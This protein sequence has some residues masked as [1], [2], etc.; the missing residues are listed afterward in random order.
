MGDDPLARPWS[1]SRDRP[2]P[3]RGQNLQAMLGR[4]WP[5]PARAPQAGQTPGAVLAGRRLDDIWARR[6]GGLRHLHS[7]LRRSRAWWAI[8]LI[9]L[10]TA[11]A[12]LLTWATASLAEGG[13]RASQAATAISAGPLVAPAPR[14]AGGLPLRLYTNQDRADQ[15]IITQL[16]QKFS[17]V[18]S[19]LLAVAARHGGP[20]ASA[21]VIRPSG[22]YGE[23]GHLDPLTSR[24]S[25]VMY[26]GLQSPA[27]LG[28][29]AS[30]IGTLMMGI[31]GKYS[32]I[33]PWP[34]AAGHRGGQGSC[35]VAWLGNTDVSVCGWAS[36]RTVGIVASPARE[37]SVGELATLLIKMRYGLQRR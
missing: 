20:A 22:L 7:A 4:A 25:W 11:A 27:S 6:P 14:S 31:L 36:G 1:V 37:T 28:Q 16:K 29:P 21:G 23:P 34:V 33:G 26:L 3:E 5:R 19:R 12:V 32:K 17:A 13:I 2:E 8:P 9:G 18:S 35:T 10:M 24:P 15:L 30:T